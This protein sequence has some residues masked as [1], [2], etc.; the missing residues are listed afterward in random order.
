MSVRKII[1]IDEEKCNGC[2]EC[3]ISCAEGALKIV[4]GKAK[5]ISDKYCDGLGACL[6]C[7]E[8][9]LKIVERDAEEFDETAV[10][11]HMAAQN[12]TQEE[13][14]L[15][16]MACGCPG[17]LVREL[18]PV[19]DRRESGP[20]SGS[21]LRNWP[22]QLHLVP[23]KAPYFEEA[24]LLIAADC[25]GFALTNLHQSFLKGRTLIIACPKL[26]DASFYEEKLAEIFRNN[27]INEIT[28]LYMTVP[29]CLGLVYLV[30]QALAKSGKSIPL[31]ALKID[32]NGDVTYE[33]EVEIAG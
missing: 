31:E 4:D 20:A 6:I 21:T 15:P 2:G 16:E 29:C 24:Q 7:P 27:N 33:R 17:S 13:S 10:Q 28:I 23:V 22:L 26:D 1:Q 19:P 25:T 5:L 3:V 14:H 32:Y 8:G 9:A 30:E 11:A 12:S 18:E